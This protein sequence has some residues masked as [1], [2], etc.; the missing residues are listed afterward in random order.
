MPGHRHRPSEWAPDLAS[1]DDRIARGIG[2][3]P[4]DIEALGW[5]RLDDRGQQASVHAA[6][7][8]GGEQEGGGEGAGSHGFVL[9]NM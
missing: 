5:W 2:F 8:Q 7:K 3:Y 9:I 4:I 6:D 1:D